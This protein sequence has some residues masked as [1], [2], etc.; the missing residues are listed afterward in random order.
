M[1]NEQQELRVSGIILLET[2][3]MSGSA[4]GSAQNRELEGL[5]MNML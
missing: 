3:R 5:R 4:M 2:H 1:R